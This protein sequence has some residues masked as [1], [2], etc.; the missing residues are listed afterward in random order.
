MTGLALSAAPAASDKERA[1]HR[2]ESTGTAVVDSPVISDTIHQSRGLTILG[3]P[4]KTI[5]ECHKT[6]RATDRDLHR[7]L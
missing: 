4:D 5:V 6:E 1:E 2:D 7:S 3:S